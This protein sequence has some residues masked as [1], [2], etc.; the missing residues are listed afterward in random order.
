[1]CSMSYPRSPSKLV[2]YKSCHTSHVVVWSNLMSIMKWQWDT[3]FPRV[4]L[5]PAVLQQFCIHTANVTHVDYLHLGLERHKLP[6]DL[7][8]PKSEDSRVA[9]IPSALANAFYRRFSSALAQSASLQP[10]LK[11]TKSWVIV[12]NFASERKVT[13]LRTK[14]RCWGLWATG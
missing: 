4:L 8:L 10:N 12:T 6:L 3:A 11:V 2:L 9:V 14:L 13:P 7:R 1:M 5:Q